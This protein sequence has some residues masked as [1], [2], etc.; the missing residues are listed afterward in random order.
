MRCGQ[1]AAGAP[2]ADWLE[3][4]AVGA[5]LLCLIHCAGLPLLLA[6]LPT[7]TQ[8]IALPE[9]LHLW[10]LAFAIPTSSATLIL[11]QRGHRALAPL[12]VGTIGL[13]LLAIGGLFLTRSQAETPVTMLGSTC[14]VFAHIANWRARHREHRHGQ[15]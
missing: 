13:S 3:R 2:V 5:S 4:A 10:L 11:G 9:S 8:V 15:T 7:L 14:L 12:L 6:V 1:R